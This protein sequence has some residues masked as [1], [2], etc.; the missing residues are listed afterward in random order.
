M[1][2]LAGG[3]GYLSLRTGGWSNRRSDTRFGVYDYESTLPGFIVPGHYDRESWKLHT[4][5]P[6]PYFP[7]DIRTSLLSKMLRQAEPRAGKIDYDVD[8]TLSGNWFQQ[9]TAGYGGVE[10]SKYWDGHLAIVPDALDPSQWRFSIG[11]FSGE[12]GNARQFGIQGNSPDPLSVTAESGL[13]K[14]ELSY[15]SHFA[16]NDESRSGLAGC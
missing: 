2:E 12:L 16:R 7:E 6:F 9:G 13:I 11:N 5:D 8:G 15:S 4:V 3:R 1:V 10:P 14:Y